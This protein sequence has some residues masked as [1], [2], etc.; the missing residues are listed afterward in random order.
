MVGFECRDVSHN[1]KNMRRHRAP[2]LGTYRRTNGTNIKFAAPRP[3]DD[4]QEDRSTKASQNVMEKNPTLDLFHV[5]PLLLHE[6]MGG[7]TG[8]PVYKFVFSCPGK[9]GAL[10][11]YRRGI[12]E[13]LVLSCMSD[14]RALFVLWSYVH[15]CVTV[16]I[17]VRS[18]KLVSTLVSWYFAGFMFRDL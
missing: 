5:C 10:V 3:C 9:A 4:P 15:A 16:M 6:M 8:R 1:C 12:R 13:L 17:S 2:E 7:G 14:R 11:R 18:G